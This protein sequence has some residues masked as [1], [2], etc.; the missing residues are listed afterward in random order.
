MKQFIAFVR[1]EFYH[2]FRD[3]RTMLILLGMPIVQIIL[4]GFAIT[5]EVKNVRV[6]V[7]D[8]SNDVVTRRIIDRLDASEY[9]TVTS[10]SLTPADM[11][12]AFKAGDIDMALVFSE[13]FS[14]NLYTGDARVQIISDA[15][16]P[17]M[18]TMQ[19]GYA[20][21]IIS[22]V[23]QEL[24]PPG[25]H[26][27]TIIPQIKLL[28]N[29]QMKSAYNFVPGV[30]G[31]ILMLI[32][33]MMT[34]ISIVREKE[35]GTMEVLLVSPVKPLFIILAK[36]V[37][38]LVLSFV[39]LVTI[40]LLSVYVLHV[41]V[42]GSLFW[43]IFVS[44]LF[45]FVSLALGLLIST[46]TRTQVAAMLVSGLMLMMPTMLLSGMIFPIESMPA[47]LQ[48]ISA[49]LPA[50]WYIQA[51]RKLMIEGVDIS[52]VLTEVGILAVMAVVLIT[53]SFRKFKYR[54]E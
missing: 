16:D 12:E 54:L 46:V 36:A 4:F 20:T 23:G 28:Y 26:A 48:G 15:T 42:T 8:P 14:D 10:C 18:A 13:R 32:C 21:N 19:A 52:L 7:L 45:I 27:T 5:T 53:V 25:V 29:P 30:M 41:P 38:Y 3:R 11:E 33:A 24:L 17:N 39:N 22:A 37:P 9:F 50:R 51:V 1:K 31:L 35:T 6:T 2:I 49:L 34:S 47:I 40:L 43:L 44:L